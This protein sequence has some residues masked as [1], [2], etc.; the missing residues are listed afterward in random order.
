MDGLGHIQ[1]NIQCKGGLAH[2]GPGG[3]Q[4]QVRLVQ[5]RDLLVHGRKACGQARQVVVALAHLSQAVQHLR[6]HL[7]QGHHVLGA[8]APADSVDLLLR[9]LQ[10]FGGLA[11]ALLH[12]GGDLGSGLGHAPQ[13]R[14]VPDDGRVL[15]HIGAGGGDLHQLGQIRT[16]GILVVGARLLHLLTDGNAV[17]GFGIGEHGVDGL[18]NL[19]VLPEVKIRRPELV[20]H[21]LDAIRVDEHGA[22]DSLLPLQ[23]VGHLPQEKVFVCHLTVT[24]L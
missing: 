22:Q 23:R 9:R 24:S 17:D 7:P 16:G 12:H 18:K 20:H 5:A 19:P 11:H 10:D 2:A 3:Q 1:C 14:L 8:L 4:N 6:Q 15:H 21:I 13:Q